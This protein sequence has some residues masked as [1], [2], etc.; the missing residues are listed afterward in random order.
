MAWYESNGNSGGSLELKSASGDIATFETNLAAPLQSVIVDVVASQAS[1]TPTPSTP[2]PISG[3]TEANITRCGVNLLHVNSRIDA[4]GAQVHYTSDDNYIYLNG[5][6]SGDGYADLVNLTITLPVGT[7]YLKAFAISGTTSNTVELYAYDG[8]NNITGNLFASERTLTLAEPQTFRFRFAVWADGTVLTD[9]KVGIVVT[10]ASGISA[11]TPYNGQTYT[12]EFGQTVYGGVLDVTRGKLTVTWAKKPFADLVGVGGW[13]RTGSGIF[14]IYP[15][16]NAFS[17]FKSPF[18]DNPKSTHF[19]YQ[20][21]GTLQNG[22]FRCSDALYFVK[23]DEPNIASMKTWLANTD[24]FFT[25]ELATPFDIDLTPVQI[26]ALVG[27]NN[28]FADCGSSAVEFVN[29]ASDET[30]MIC[31]T[32]GQSITLPV[33]ASEHLTFKFDLYFLYGNGDFCLMADVWSGSGWLVHTRYWDLAFR[34]DAGGGSHVFPITP[35]TKKSI[36]VNT[37]D[38][39]LI[40]DGNVKTTGHTVSY[41][42][43]EYIRMFGMNASNSCMASVGVVDV[44]KDDVL[45]MHLVPKKD[46]NTGAGYYYDTIGGQSYYSE[47]ANP[48]VYAEM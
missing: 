21:S 44:Y 43:G 48:L 18:T 33:K 8:S 13:N 17:N 45:Y 31:S 28:V 42:S 7:Y 35:Y 3:Y 26:R 11:F 19:N 14:Y 24:G 5:T 1:G 37:F 15:L 27:V 36:E 47:T 32:G 22:C 41:T 2:L 23:D 38:G 25:Y 9:Y 34:Y 16:S 40:I 39:T 10:T 6:K 29:K 30:A 12:V 46:E 4:T 20:T